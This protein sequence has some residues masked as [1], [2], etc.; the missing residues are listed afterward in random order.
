MKY[1]VVD[2]ETTGLNPD[3]DVIMEMAWRLF[4]NYSKKTLAACSFLLDIS[5]KIIKEDIENLT[6]ISYDMI[7]SF[8]VNELL[9]FDLFSDA[10]RNCDF[11]AAHNV[12]FE[13]SFL[14]KKIDTNLFSSIKWLDTMNDLPFD[15]SIS[16]RKLGHICSDHGILIEGAH[17]ALP[18]V[19][20]TTKLISM[21]SDEDIHDHL[22][23]EI[24]T[25]IAN[26]SFEEKD[27]AKNAGFLWHPATKS[28]RI[29]AREYQVDKITSGLNFNYRI[30]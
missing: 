26:V 27:L 19:D 2:L 6:G 21:F 30:I 22:T 16:S 12:E 5:G 8:S 23:S 11:V 9:A 3:E 13:K 4:D 7:C 17:R 24:K 1:L 14:S 18:D 20:A 10:I 25:I 28:W 15:I 29:Q